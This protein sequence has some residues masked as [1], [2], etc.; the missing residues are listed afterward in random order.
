M[1]KQIPLQNGMY[2]LVDDDDYEKVKNLTWSITSE[3]ENILLKVT[4]NINKKSIYLSQMLIGN[5]KKEKVIHKNGDNL[6]F[7]KN[8]LCL[9]NQ[10]QV[11]FTSKSRRNS[12]SKYKGV[13]W[14][15]SSRKWY[16]SIMH[17]GK[18]YHLGRFDDEK[19]AALTYNQ[20]A[21]KLFGDFAYQNIIGE[22]NSVQR[23]PKKHCIKRKKKN[24]TS[25][26]FGVSQNKKSNNWMAFIHINGE[27]KHLGMFKTE[28]E[29]AKVYDKKA[30]ELLGDKVRLNFPD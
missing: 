28:E 3:H 27:K 1:V 10:Q 5:K 7:R 2:A 30:L 14:D 6:D 17:N 26:Y 29:A 25:K 12:T 21:I 16:A 24:A 23:I 18:Q 20:A 19:Q 4:T 11:T 15:K 8:N 22:D 13:C 9:A